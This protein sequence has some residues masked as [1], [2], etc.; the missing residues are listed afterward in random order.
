ML[1]S[2][3]DAAHTQCAGL[4]LR[5]HALRQVTLKGSIMR[6][7]KGNKAA[8][9]PSK[10]A[11]AALIRARLEKDGDNLSCAEFTTLVSRFDT[12]TAKS[13][14]RHR[15]ESQAK[16]LSANDF[17]PW[18]TPEQNEIH[19]AVMQIEAEEHAKGIVH[20]Q[21]SDGSTE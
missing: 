10:K 6:F 5:R 2:R 3:K 4:T 19:R 14:R 9:K 20:R 17:Y 13:P 1:V 18:L 15:E 8:A 12:L 21:Y 11:V 7:Q 16:K